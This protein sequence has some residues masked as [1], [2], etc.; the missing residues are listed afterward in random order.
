MLDDCSVRD[1]P[2][3][4][5]LGDATGITPATDLG[6]ATGNTPCTELAVA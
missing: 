6:D 3:H 4:L 2:P 5:E 1:A